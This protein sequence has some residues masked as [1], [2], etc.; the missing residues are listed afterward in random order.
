[1]RTVPGTYRRRRGQFR[2][3]AHLGFAAPSLMVGFGDV[4]GLLYAHGAVVVTVLDRPAL[5]RDRMSGVIEEKGIPCVFR[6]Y[7]F[8]L[9]PH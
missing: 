1:M 6:F 8:L 4:A 9:P 5:P 3:L 2:R 7:R